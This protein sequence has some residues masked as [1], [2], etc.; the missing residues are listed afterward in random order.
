MAHVSLHD[1][2]RVLFAVV[3]AKGPVSVRLTQ[4]SPAVLCDAIK[5]VRHQVEALRP[6]RAQHP[7]LL[8]VALAEG[9][10]LDGS[11]FN[12]VAKAFAGNQFTIAGILKSPRAETLSDA[13]DLL[14]QDGA[15]DA[16][17]AD[18][19]LFQLQVEEKIRLEEEAEAWA[20][21]L[22]WDAHFNHERHMGESAQV[23]E[24][25][26]AEALRLDWEAA[27]I[28]DQRFNRQQEAV[29]WTQALIDD[30][31]FNHARHLAESA[32]AW[33]QAHAEYAAFIALR[34]KQKEAAAWEE[35]LVQ[36][37]AFD[38]ALRLKEEA[39]LEQERQQ[40]LADW[41]AALAYDA[42]VNRANR[43]A[44]CT[45][46]AVLEGTGLPADVQAQLLSMGQVADAQ[47][48]PAVA[49]VVSSQAEDQGEEADD[50]GDGDVA[51]VAAP[52][53][54]GIVLD[55]GRRTQFFDNRLR[56]GSQLQ[57][58]G[59]DLVIHGCVSSGAEAIADGNIM[60][61]G[62]VNGKLYAGVKGDTSARVICNDFSAE[63]VSIAGVYSLFEEVPLAIRN[64]PV[65]FWLEN[66]E[67][68]YRRIEKTSLPA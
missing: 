29:A 35:A 49:E 18:L 7:V 66:D 30:A 56:S 11:A 14:V 20:E 12:V 24:Q 57:A 43:L 50:G 58:E 67:L 32:E 68:H 39:R 44:A 62:K 2:R 52:P 15:V 23:W 10:A 21:A 37:A 17:A 28:E 36:N 59:A 22:A 38:E 3:P 33:E 46:Q 31:A 34:L 45:R 9:P 48:G 65:M 1:S 47:A 16:T 42:V 6:D 27:L 25:A 51:V 26:H 4:S 53:V 55:T 13:S 61:W 63:L 64:Q 54:A 19:E 8:D 40:M 5:D 41:D 60:V